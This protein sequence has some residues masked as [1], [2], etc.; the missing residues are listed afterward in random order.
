MKQQHR[1]YQRGRTVIWIVL[2]VMVGA[3][4]GAYFTL[5]AQTPQPAVPAP[6]VAAS[7]DLIEILQAPTCA[8]PVIAIT[9]IS[10]G[11]AVVRG[12]YGVQ[13][14]E[15]QRRIQKA[16]AA[17]REEEVRLRAVQTQRR[18]REL[19]DLTVNLA[20]GEE[21][22]R[23]M[24]GPDGQLLLVRP[25]L[26]TKPV[27]RLDPDEVREESDQVRVAAMLANA[28][29]YGGRGHSGGQKSQLSLEMA[30]LSMLNGGGS[31][32]R[33]LP[34]S[35]QILTDDEGQMLGDKRND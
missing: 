18:L 15:A 27:S 34:G 26:A 19:N 20:T 31:P 13:R 10:L 5:R 17:E 12:Y 11:F 28:A 9:L 2:L 21:V 29:R 7:P 24:E 6:A 25:G 35:I 14:L 3:A 22:A 32:D 8:V 33:R 4:L 30:A 23:L 1:Q 16:E